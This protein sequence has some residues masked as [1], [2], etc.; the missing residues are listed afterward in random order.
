MGEKQLAKKLHALVRPHTSDENLDYIDAPVILEDWHHLAKICGTY[1]ENNNLFDTQ[2][3]LYEAWKQWVK[4]Q[5]R[6]SE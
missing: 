5:S 6:S 2:A 4:N 1:A 3:P